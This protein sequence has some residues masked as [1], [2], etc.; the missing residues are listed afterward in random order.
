MT[1]R[2]LNRFSVA[3]LAEMTRRLAEVASGRAAPDRV[4]TGARVLSTYSERILPD[5]EVWI[6]GGRIAAVKPAGSHRG[7]APR[8]DAA[9]GL[10]DRL[11]GGGALSMGL[12]V[13]VIVLRPDI[14]EADGERAGGPGAAEGQRAERE[15]GRAA[16]QVSA[17][18]R[19]G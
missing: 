1:A 8:Y 7:A 9:G 14:D 16:E 5:R 12:V 3:P 11:Q 2:P 13:A 10:I 15:G 17:G 4:I 19:M 18:E 6:A